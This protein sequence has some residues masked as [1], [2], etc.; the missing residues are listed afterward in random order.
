MPN[1]KTQFVL[2]KCA[3]LM[4]AIYRK[5]TETLPLWESIDC[6]IDDLACFIQITKDSSQVVKT[7][8]HHFTSFSRRTSVGR[9]QFDPAFFAG[10]RNFTIL[11][12]SLVLTILQKTVAHQTQ[13]NQYRFRN[14]NCSLKVVNASLI[15][16]KLGS[17]AF[18]RDFC[19]RVSSAFLAQQSQS[20]L[21]LTV[22]LAP[23]SLGKC[24]GYGKFLHRSRLSSSEIRLSC[25]KNGS[26]KSYSSH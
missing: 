18:K 6:F 12:V 1:R 21:T 24:F 25:S 4:G 14:Q 17:I 7:E 15:I 13:E 5:H 10:F 16:L 22:D 9:I 8:G 2:V 26:L 3:D 20:D 19:F 11:T 23:I